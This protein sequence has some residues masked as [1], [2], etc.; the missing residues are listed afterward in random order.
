[1]QKPIV[2][3]LISSC[4]DTRSNKWNPNDGDTCGA[5]PDSL[6]VKLVPEKGRASMV[7][8]LVAPM[9]VQLIAE[10]GGSGG[11]PYSWFGDVAQAFVGVRKF[12]L[13][14]VVLSNVSG[15][16]WAQ[17]NG[18]RTAAQILLKSKYK[19]EKPAPVREHEPLELDAD[20]NPKTKGTTRAFNVYLCGEEIDCVF[21][22]ANTPIDADEVRE[23]LINHD[24]YSPN[25]TVEEE[26]GAE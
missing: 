5:C 10:R 22:G 11:N 15:N 14:L 4:P 9:L 13:S 19:E 20:G 8:R 17:W 25:I 21:Y 24:G 3:V 1:M 12:D 16:L 6:L 7:F 26:G 2:N 18:K 23:S